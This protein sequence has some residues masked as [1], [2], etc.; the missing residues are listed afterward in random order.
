MIN[1]FISP[2]FVRII[3]FGK[4]GITIWPFGIYFRH[5][6]S[7]N[8]T[9]LIHEL[10]HWEQEKEMLGIFFYL[11][12]FIEWLLKL[13]FYGKEAYRNISFER[14]ARSKIHISYLKVRRRYSWV[15]YI[16]KIKL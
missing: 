3:T 14:E 12:Y 13:P 16:K 7:L 1:L 10:I 4:D 11:W 15:K 8:S 2:N 9:L 5:G 6:S